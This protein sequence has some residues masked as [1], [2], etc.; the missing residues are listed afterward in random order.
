MTLITSSVS[1]SACCASTTTTTSICNN[2]QDSSRG[3]LGWA[4]L[5]WGESGTSV[6]VRPCMLWIPE[7]PTNNDE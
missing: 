7:N 2:C 6:S 5:G 4:G 1:V 3:G